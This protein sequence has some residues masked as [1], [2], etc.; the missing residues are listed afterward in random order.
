VID[1]EEVRDLQL[2]YLKSGL[3]NQDVP[4]DHAFFASLYRFATQNGVKYVLSGGNFATESI[5]PQ[6]WHGDAMDVINLRAVHRKYGKAK[7]R[8][9]PTISFFEY[10]FWYPFV[11]GM[12]TMRPL[13]FMPYDKNEAA[14][15]LSCKTGWRSYGRKHG[16]SRFTKL[17]QNY[18]LPK[19]FGYDK[20]LPHLS[21]LIVSG[22]MTRDE[23]LAMLAEPLYDPNDLTADIAF[24]CKKLGLTEREFCDIMA[25]PSHVYTDFPNWDRYKDFVRGV[26][27]VIGRV[28]GREISVYS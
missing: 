18:Y 27:G 21:S 8:H 20:R 13:N 24:F 11:K 1:W 25:Q 2:A 14:A 6:S 3:A 5:F 26:R 9:Y 10:Y 28:L 17:F 19:K 22:Q 12:R 7:L 4:Q 23:A 15:E 16:E